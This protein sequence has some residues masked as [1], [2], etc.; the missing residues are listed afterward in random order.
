MDMSIDSQNEPRESQILGIDYGQQKVGLA[1]AEMETK[2][3]FALGTLK[4]DK[5]FWENLADILKKENISKVI[6]GIPSHINRKEVEYPS[7]KFAEIF[8]S[9]FKIETEFADEMFTTKMAKANLIAKGM[10]AVDKYDDA[11]A[12]KIILQGW[13]DK[14]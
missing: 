1:K 2:M 3:A 13:L 12:A 10:K 8:K 14:S 7:E 6:I 5:Y 9:K 4:N 11:E